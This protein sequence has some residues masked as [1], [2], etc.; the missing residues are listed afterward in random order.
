MNNEEHF[1]QIKEKE[2][3]QDQIINLYKFYYNI[4]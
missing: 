4:Q 3:I 1:K 2:Y